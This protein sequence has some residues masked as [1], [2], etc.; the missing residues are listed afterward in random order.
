MRALTI[1]VTTDDAERLRGALML[2]SSQAAL[3]GVAR[4][5]LQLDSVS[6]LRA[7]MTAARDEAHQAAGLPT[8]ST[9]LSESLALGVAIVACQSGMAL[10]GLTADNL[11]PGVTIGGPISLLQ[12]VGDDAR[13]LIA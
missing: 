3:G 5:F 11:A 9:L 10:H 13:L 7:P 6:L 2:A 4:L 12:E 1:F 8:L